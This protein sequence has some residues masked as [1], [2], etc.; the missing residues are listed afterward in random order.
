MLAD[1]ETCRPGET[2]SKMTGQYVGQQIKNY[3]VTEHVAEGGIGEVYLGT[4][5]TIGRQVVIK[6]IDQ[7]LSD[8]PAIYEQFLAAVKVIAEL[9][10]PNII[11][12]YDF[13]RTERGNLYYITEQLKGEPLHELMRT[14]GRMTL[15]EAGPY[16]EQICAGL[17]A[18]HER[19]VVHRDLRP[20]IIFILDTLQL[21]LKI[22]DFGIAKVLDH[23]PRGLAKTAKGIVMAK[24]LTVSPEQ[25]A[26]RHDQLSPQTDLYALG[27]T[28][29]WMLAGHPPFH[30]G[31]P[32]VIQA[33]HITDPP[34]PLT[35][36]V[37]GLPDEVVEVVHRCLAKAPEDR[38]GSAAE[39]AEVFG[40]ALGGAGT[41][42]PLRSAALSDTLPPIDP[43]EL[44]G[45]KK[46]VATRPFGTVETPAPEAPGR[47][48]SA[49]TAPAR[50]EAA[51]PGLATGQ[52]APPRDGAACSPAA[53]PAPAPERPALA[54]PASDTLTPEDLEAAGRPTEEL[55]PEEEDRSLETGSDLIEYQLPPDSAVHPMLW[56]AKVRTVRGADGQ[57]EQVIQ[58]ADQPSRRGIWI[59]VVVAAAVVA[60]G[61]ALYAVAA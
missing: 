6:T 50:N 49:R 38:P 13:G 48:A 51:R 32:A 56:G 52:S 28:L 53:H 9:D 36:L 7:A 15:H 8:E 40:R 26:G 60:L 21:R 47:P 23:E 45:G 54:A 27:A 57:L 3:L 43:A 10:H 18:A 33:A 14:C 5:P 29:Y 42:P 12:I 31:P 61:L 30:E 41:R 39:V 37:P 59:V 20:G 25:A 22:V 46:K 35:G 4:H 34:P 19:L 2:G 55:E 1:I 16:V 58:T 24:P 11:D 17:V 44:E